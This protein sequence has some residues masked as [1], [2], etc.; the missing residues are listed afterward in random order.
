MQG[1]CVLAAVLFIPFDCPLIER[2]N[3]SRSAGLSTDKNSR[4]LLHTHEYQPWPQSPK[5]ERT[6]CCFSVCGGHRSSAQ[7]FVPVA[8]GTGTSPRRPELHVACCNKKACGRP[9]GAGLSHCGRP[10]RSQ[11]Q[12]WCR[13]SC[14]LVL[15]KILS[16]IKASRAIHEAILN[17]YTITIC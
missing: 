3:A 17:I 9:A 13:P 7:H 2:E 15:V 12:T 16:F 1:H 6:N 14:P 4:R 11:A 10:T 5:P 8:H